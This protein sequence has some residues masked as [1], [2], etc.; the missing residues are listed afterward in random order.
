[1]AH[2]CC[3]FINS[4]LALAWSAVKSI[5][6]NQIKSIFTVCFI[7]LL[8]FFTQVKFRIFVLHSS[9]PQISYTQQLDAGIHSELRRN[10]LPVNVKFHYLSLNRVYGNRDE[11]RKNAVAKQAMEEFDPDVVIAIGE[12]S[13]FLV[14]NFYKHKTRPA[15]VYA[16]ILDPD[17]YYADPEKASTVGIRGGVPTPAIEELLR[18]IF[19]DRRVNIAVIGRDNT[20]GRASLGLVSTLQGEQFKVQTTKLLSYFDDLKSTIQILNASD[21][22]LLLVRNYAGLRDKTTDLEVPDRDIVAYIERYSRALPIGLQ[23]NFVHDG[24]GLAIETSRQEIGR[25]AMNMALDWLDRS[26]GDY[27]PKNIVTKHFDIALRE[28]LLSRR[29]ISLPLVYREHARVAGYLYN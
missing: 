14:S 22:D 12:D 20:T 18:S 10:L 19:G 17:R 25:H 13:N 11:S 21:I 27:P 24:A 5:S 23:S 15:I 4:L 1:M 28:D 16:N 29:G 8:V 2:Y 26:T 7:S 6:R 3:V 9:D